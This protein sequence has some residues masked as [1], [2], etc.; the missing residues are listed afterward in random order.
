[1]FNKFFESNVIGKKIMNK[2]NLMKNDTHFY[3]NSIDL[4]LQ[5]DFVSIN[6]KNY[7]INLKQKLI[8]AS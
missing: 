6:N 1:M 8:K 7:M 5:N 4:F 2:T 3:I